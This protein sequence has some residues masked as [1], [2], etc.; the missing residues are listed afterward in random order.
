MRMFAPAA[1][2]IARDLGADAARP[3]GNHTTW[4]RS[5]EFSIL[6]F[7]PRHDTAMAPHRELA[8]NTCRRCTLS[9][10]T[11]ISW[12]QITAAA[13]S[14]STIHGYGPVCAGLGTTARVR[15]N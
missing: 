13:G 1:W 6:G 3:A 5:E 4:S 2:Q 7:M 10:C 11:R 14:P 9:A 12:S 15:T 8:L